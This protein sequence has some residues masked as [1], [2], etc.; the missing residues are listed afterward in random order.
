MLN[1]C[2]HSAHLPS[3]TIGVG[4]I[5]EPLEEDEKL[6]RINLLLANSKST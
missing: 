3:V 5:S 4:I 2:I 6:V 1:Y